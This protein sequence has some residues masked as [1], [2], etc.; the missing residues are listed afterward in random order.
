MCVDLYIIVERDDKGGEKQ[1]A[2]GNSRQHRTNQSAIGIKGKARKRPP[3]QRSK[4][5]QT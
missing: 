4:K 2:G 5:A 3:K 1:N